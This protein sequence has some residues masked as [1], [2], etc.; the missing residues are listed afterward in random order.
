MWNKTALELDE[1]IEQVMKIE[2][3]IRVTKLSNEVNRMRVLE[4]Y[5]STPYST[6]NGI[7]E[8]GIVEIFE[9]LSAG[10]WDRA[11]ALIAYYQIGNT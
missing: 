5:K 11:S 4:W 2:N 3:R 9:A 10:D 6:P 1:M 7:Q 8:H